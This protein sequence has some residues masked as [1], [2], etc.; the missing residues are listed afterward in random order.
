MFSGFGDFSVSLSR[1]WQSPVE[2]TEGWGRNAMLILRTRRAAGADVIAV[3]L[4]YWNRKRGTRAMPA[5]ADIDPV[6]IR[7]ILPNIILVD[8][9]CDPLDFRCRLV[10]SEIERIARASPHGRRFSQSRNFRPGSQGWADYER[11]V[12]LAKPVTGPFAYAGPDRSVRGVSHCLMPLSAD[13][14]T[15]NMIFNATAIERD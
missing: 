3:A 9:L 8:V 12:L 10:G 6:E 15:V 14:Q 7:H 4:A 2:R 11:A 5:R 1:N 13:G